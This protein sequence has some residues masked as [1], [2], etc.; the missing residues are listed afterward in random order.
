MPD[1][2][3]TCG[4]YA[5]CRKKISYPIY[6]ACFIIREWRC[7]KCDDA[8]NIIDEQNQIR[9]KKEEEQKKNDWIKERNKILKEY[10]WEKETKKILK[11]IKEHGEK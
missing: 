8:E 6:S 4:E 10:R 2:C 7:K 5:L 1:K 11:E 3:D 9:Y